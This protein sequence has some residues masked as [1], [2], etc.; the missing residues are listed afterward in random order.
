MAF[1]TSAADVRHAVEIAGEAG[2]PIT[3]RGAGTSMSGQSIGTGL[4]LDTS[5][6]LNGIREFDP[7]KRRIV[8]EPGIVLD[9]LNR[10]LAPHGLFFPIDVATSSRAT[11]GGMTGNN[12]AGARSIR[13]GH[14][15]EQVRGIEA[16][17]ASGQ[18]AWF[19]APPSSEPRGSQAPLAPMS[20]HTAMQSLYARESEELA[21]R[22][23]RVPRHVAGYALHRLGRPGATLADV[24]VGSEGTLA[25]FTAIELQ[26]HAVPEARALGV[27]R[28]PSVRT[29]LGA[30]PAIVSLEPT[31][32]ELVDRTLLELAADIP[33]FRPALG[34]TLGQQTGRDSE[35][36]L[37]L[38]GAILLVEFSGSDEAEVRSRLDDL[39][40]VVR[41]AGC[42][43]MLRAMDRE[44]QTEIWE[45]RKAGLNIATSMKEPRKPIAF[46]EDCVIP[47]DRLTEWHDRLSAVVERHDT[48]AIWYAHASVGCLHVRPALDLRDPDD[49]RRLRS[50]AEEAF[51]IAR[52]L[53]GS[54]SGEHGDGIVRSEFIE[55]MLGSR[56][57]GAFEEIKAHFDPG[58]LLNPGR[59]VHA[60]AMDDRSLFRYFPEYRPE[61]LDTALD[62]SEWHGFAGAIEMCNNNGAC[63]QRDPGV[64]CPSFRAT[65]D[66]RHSTRGRAN[67]LRLAIS[68]QLGKD[69]WNSPDLHDAMDLCIGCKACRRECPAGVD[70]ARMK[71]EYLYRYRESHGLTPRERAMAYLPRLAPWISRVPTFANAR[72]HA[73]P[74]GRVVDRTLGLASDR[75]L[76]RWAGKPFRPPRSV[77]ARNGR[78]PKGRV[79]GGGRRVALFV[80]TF[81]RYFEPENAHAAIRVLEAAGYR[82]EVPDGGRP[83]CCGR[84]YLN[85]GLVDEARAEMDRFVS[86]YVRYADGNV[87]IVGLE[88]SCLLTLR[89][90]LLIVRPGPG[91]EIVASHA[92]LFSELIAEEALDRLPLSSPA[93]GATR[94]L[95][96]GHCHE[97]AFGLADGTLRA[98]EAVPDLEVSQIRA[99]CCGM[100]G[101]FG[102]EAEHVD[103]S[104]RMGEMD[105]APA[106]RE[107]PEDH[108]IVANGTSCRHQIRDLTG[109]EA[110][111]LAVVLDHALRGGG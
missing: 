14:M 56:L 105:L 54:H 17:L 41:E 3:P 72:N 52:D 4:V 110:K 40:D 5:R 35:G 36:P 73:G 96:H 58:S 22:L 103:L 99:G 28:F 100:A 42:S 68:G 84:T 49:V 2:V 75:P 48:R 76:P 78:S 46:I 38:P 79:R 67:A 64:M 45:V 50:I 9:E 12:S 24:L 15:V 107:A 59:I 106:V 108:W 29:A 62:W 69:A 88:P 37:E 8:V 80:D 74:L 60:P 39:E 92:R 77:A 19:G 82:V 47:I 65:Q 25:F 86:Q 1:P 97:K 95:V 23:P 26:L 34:K 71:I 102:Y 66:E 85:V 31:A 51:S 21:R 111:H 55:D 61:H 53:G 94:A 81:T 109:R 13:Y 90:E 43:G 10:F 33:A 30:T 104:R 70:M 57:V 98:L 83:A 11:I 93:G 16:I 63:R 32:V 101:S 44:L 18:L 89:D 87:P 20:L 27:C 91:A 6:H 7:D